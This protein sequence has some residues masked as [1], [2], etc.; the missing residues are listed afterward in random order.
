MFAVLAVI[1]FALDLFG[2]KSLTDH[3]MFWVVLGLALLAAHMVLSW[4]PWSGTR[5][6]S[7]R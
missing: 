1:C 5:S 3:A 2:A 6:G 4:T 7:N